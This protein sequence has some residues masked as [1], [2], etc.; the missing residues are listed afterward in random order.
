ML[1]GR[2]QNARI[3]AGDG[4]RTITPVGIEYPGFAGCA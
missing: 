2:Y 3:D 4:Q 1:A